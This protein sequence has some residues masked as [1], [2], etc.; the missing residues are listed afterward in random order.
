MTFEQMFDQPH[1]IL[2]HIV[3]CQTYFDVPGF[4]F[5][6]V[7]SRIYDTEIVVL[8]LINIFHT[9]LQNFVP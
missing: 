8:K 3:V 2:E 5:Y 6:P 1:R 4:C 7:Q 9:Q